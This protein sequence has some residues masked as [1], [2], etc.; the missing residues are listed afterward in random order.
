M[1]ALS[2]KRPCSRVPAVVS[3]MS[4]RTECPA[5]SSV[6]A[7]A[8]QSTPL[9]RKSL[10]MFPSYPPLRYRVFSERR[11]NNRESERVVFGEQSRCMIES[12]TSPRGIRRSNAIAGVTP[13]G[14]NNRLTRRGCKQK[15]SRSG[16]NK[17]MRESDTLQ[18]AGENEEELRGR[19]N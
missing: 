4:E 9:Q 7:V 8:S 3:K 11:G 19:G 17:I 6:V 13:Q 18:I 5:R 16:T 14:V 12:S 10:A 2:P 1:Y 15:C